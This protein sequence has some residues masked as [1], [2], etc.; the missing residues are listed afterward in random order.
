MRKLSA[1]SEKPELEIVLGDRMYRNVDWKRKDTILL[2][3]KV[4]GYI[5]VSSDDRIGVTV[6]T[7]QGLTKK[8]RAV[9]W[10]VK[11]ALLRSHDNIKSPSI[12]GL[13][14]RSSGAVP[15]WDGMPSPI[16]ECVNQGIITT[17]CGSGLP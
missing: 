10:C 3:A 15:A 12:T 11:L 9:D 1:M 5:Y 4:I 2:A 13:T 14:L 7:S 17:S 16:G 6:S 8:G